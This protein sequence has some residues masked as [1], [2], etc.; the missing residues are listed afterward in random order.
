MCGERDGVVCGVVLEGVAE[1]RKGAAVR[2]L[3]S[4]VREVVRGAGERAMAWWEQAVRH[5]FLIRREDEVVVSLPLV[6]FERKTVEDVVHELHRRE[7]VG[8]EA[9]EGGPWRVRGVGPQP[10]WVEVQNVP[11][12]ASSGMVGAALQR[13]P[14]I[15]VD[16]P[17]VRVRMGEGGVKGVGTGEGV[18]APGVEEEEDK[19]AEEEGFEGW[20]FFSDSWRVGLVRGVKRVPDRV[21]MQLVE[22]GEPVVCEV[23]VLGS[24]E[25]GVIPI[26][27]CEVC[28]LYGHVGPC[29]HKWWRPGSAIPSSGY[30]P[31]LASRRWE[32]RAGRPDLSGGRV[33]GRP[34]SEFPSLAG[35]AAVGTARPARGDGGQQAKSGKKEVGGP[36]DPTGKQCFNCRQWDHFARDCPQPRLCRR[37][38][39]P[40]HVAVECDRLPTPPQAPGTAPPQA[41]TTPRREELSEGPAEE[42]PTQLQVED[43]RDADQ[44]ED[45]RDR[46]EDA[47]GESVPAGV[48]GE[49]QEVQC[50]EMA[51]GISLESVLAERPRREELA[52][53]PAEELPTQPPEEDMRED[54]RGQDEDARGESVPAG[55]LEE[56]PATTQHAEEVQCEE[57]V[58]GIPLESVLERS[59][60]EDREG[61]EEEGFTPVGRRVKQRRERARGE[62]S[63][64]Q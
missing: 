44:E 14:G 33:G 11:E 59:L 42:L 3:A 23:R 7:Q 54:V 22:G 48:L 38:F 32:R 58:D 63:S 21:A 26:G 30:A 36:P 60:E 25:T 16:V 15:R 40:G 41:T 34:A 24:R 31:P 29:S 35:A 56:D 5:V 46:E 2:A 18:G 9:D 4:E 10:L 55:V 57:T 61:A 6:G 13:L 28:F 17:A 62:S 49:D 37:C 45:V 64:S 50:V 51:D 43:A 8:G 52:E 20:Q 47:R 12:G 39:Q 1:D 19:S 53:G 27:L